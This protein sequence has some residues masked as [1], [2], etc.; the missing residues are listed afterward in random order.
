[1]AIIFSTRWKEEKKIEAKNIFKAG[2]SPKAVWPYSKAVWAWDLLFC[3]WQIALSPETGELIEWWIEEQTRQVCRNIGAM[4]S[5]FWL[6]FKDVVKT[7]VYLRSITHFELMNDIYKNYFLVKP[8][9]TTIEVSNL[10]KNASVEIEVI[11]KK[12]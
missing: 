2:K 4:L 10:P 6:S 7:T 3:S 11:A 9:R 12:S 5:E 8:A 1:M